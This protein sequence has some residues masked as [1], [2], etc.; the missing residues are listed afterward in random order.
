[1]S[2]KKVTLLLLSLH[3]LFLSLSPPL[4]RARAPSMTPRAGKSLSSTISRCLAH[5]TRA[6]SRVTALRARL[7]PPP[8][9][10]LFFILLLFLLFGRESSSEGSNEK[11]DRNGNGRTRRRTMHTKLCRTRGFRGLTRPPAL[12]SK[13]SS[14]DVTFRDGDRT[15]KISTNTRT[16]QTTIV[17]FYFSLSP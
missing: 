7:P 1:M 9:P 5:D 15:S 11:E 10:P 16:N 12:Y 6:R 17:F 3:S 14:S 2:I 8:P 13:M 4:F